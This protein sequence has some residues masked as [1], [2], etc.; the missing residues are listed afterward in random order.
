[1]SWVHEVHS[2]WSKAHESCWK[3]GA[4]NCVLSNLV[5]NKVAAQLNMDPIQVQLINDGAHGHDM[6]WLDEHIKKPNRMP[7]RDSLKEVV[8]AGKKAF[9]W[10]KKWH[11]PGNAQAP[12]CRMHGV[13][14][15]AVAC[16][17]TG[18]RKGG[19]PGISVARDG[20]ATNFLPAHGLRPVRSFHL[21]QIVAD[22]IGLRYEDVKI[23]FKRLFY[24]DAV[25]AYGFHGLQPEYVRPGDE[26]RRMK[27]LIL[28]YAVKFRNGSTNINY[29]DNVP[30]TVSP[31]LGKKIEDLDIKDS[32][33]F[34]RQ[35]RKTGFR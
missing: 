30:A 12:K 20:T 24:F 18:A 8:E 14:F 13:G 15:Y 22:E 5:I 4:S 21:L 32:F 27:K 1:M 33:V 19:V 28:E 2:Y 23:E 3:D 29:G 10:D 6:A 9:D 31:L 17:H 16:W 11:P 26:C 35:I 25:S 34:E 7:L